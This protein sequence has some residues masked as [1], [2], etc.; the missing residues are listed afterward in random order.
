MEGVCE[1]K[2]A[3][4]SFFREQ[5]NKAK[6][7]RTWGRMLLLL[8]LIAIGGGML[9]YTKSNAAEKI[10]G[11]TM[12]SDKVIESRLAVIRDYYYNKQGQLTVKTISKDYSCNMSMNLGRAG[13]AI[14]S[15]IGQCR[16][17][18]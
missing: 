5:K 16:D 12:F 2:E 7:Y 17:F 13:K 6:K 4:S 9:G 11:H 8:F 14:G 15:C 1:M 18:L 10:A 3:K